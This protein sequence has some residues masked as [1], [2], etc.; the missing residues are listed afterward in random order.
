MYT[1]SNSFVFNSSLRS[2]FLNE[3]EK[4]KTELEYK[5]S[6]SIKEN[7]NNTK[8]EEY[9]LNSELELNKINLNI[10][11]NKKLYENEFYKKSELLNQAYEK[12][13]NENLLQIM[14]AQM[15]MDK[16]MQNNVNNINNI[17]TN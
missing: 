2:S 8:I 9:N 11:K 4:Q 14:A 1:L 7:E 12:Q 16:M 5:I 10:E 15:M 3:I 6:K 13:N 17:N